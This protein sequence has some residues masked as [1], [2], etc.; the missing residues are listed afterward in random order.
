M[1]FIMLAQFLFDYGL[2]TLCDRNNDEHTQKIEFARYDPENEGRTAYKFKGD[3][4]DSSM[5][6]WWWLCG[7]KQFVNRISGMRRGKIKF[8]L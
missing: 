4:V 3:C 5:H 8:G 2:I 7:G 6:C 1:D